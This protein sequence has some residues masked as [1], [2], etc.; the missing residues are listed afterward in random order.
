M[1]QPFNCRARSAHLTHMAISEDE[2]AFWRCEHCFCTKIPKFWSKSVRVH[3]LC[4]LGAATTRPLVVV[5]FLLGNG[6]GLE[7]L[8]TLLLS[9]ILVPEMDVQLSRLVVSTGTGVKSS[10]FFSIDGGVVNDSLT[11]FS[12]SLPLD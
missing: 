8:D 12:A 9:C 6:G 7:S 2:G 11:V 1:V 5:V 3:F 4:A 10:I